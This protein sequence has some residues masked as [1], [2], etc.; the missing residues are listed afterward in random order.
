M[1]RQTE[2]QAPDPLVCGRVG[3]AG[4]FRRLSQDG[5]MATRFRRRGEARRVDQAFS[6]R[7]V[8]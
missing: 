3:E 2:K 8:H 5:K 7:A 4:G 1:I 6:Q